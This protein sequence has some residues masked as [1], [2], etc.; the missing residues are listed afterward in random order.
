MCT[1]V[2]GQ[3]TEAMLAKLEGNTHFK[4]IKKISDVIVLLKLIREIYFDV[5]SDCY[6]FI[7]QQSPFFPQKIVSY[8]KQ[9]IFGGLQK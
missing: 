4:D 6:P 2:L 1:V 5:E 8:I 3:C 7:S 9:F